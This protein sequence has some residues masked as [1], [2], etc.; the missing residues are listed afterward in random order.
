MRWVI[1]D[2]ETTGND[3]KNGHRVIEVGCVELVERRRTGR[4]FQAYLNPDRDSDEGA[5]Q[6]HGLSRE[7]LADKPRFGEIADRLRDFLDGA[8]VIIHNAP[9]D[10]GFLDSE[11][12]RIDQAA[13]PFSQ[14]LTVTDSLQ[15]ARQKH[16]GQPNSLNALCRRYAVDSSGRTLHGALLDS[17]LL[18]DVYLALTAGQS[19]FELALESDG[20]RTHLGDLGGAMPT[21]VIEPS[22]AELMRFEARLEQ[23]ARGRAGGPMW[24]ELSRLDGAHAD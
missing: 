6:V 19:A 9:F 14:S 21:R 22:A 3:P 20:P 11:Y 15:V 13:P 10:L 5:L 4:T 17:E 24:R 1:L 12:A 2:T 7:F 8:E 18:A 23:L 16:P